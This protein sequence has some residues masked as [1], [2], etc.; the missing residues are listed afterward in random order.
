M[1]MNTVITLNTYIMAANN[2]GGQPSLLMIPYVSI[3]FEPL[4]PRCQ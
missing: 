2:S 3:D 4:V 1:N